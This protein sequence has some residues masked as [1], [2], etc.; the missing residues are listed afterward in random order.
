MNDKANRFLD[1]PVDPFGRTLAINKLK[2]HIPK[3]PIII[4]S[5]S[6]HHHIITKSYFVTA[7]ITHTRHSDRE[8]ERVGD[9]HTRIRLS[10]SPYLLYFARIVERDASKQSW[11]KPRHAKPSVK[12]GFDL[13]KFEMSR[14]SEG[15]SRYFET[16]LGLARCEF[17]LERLRARQR[18]HRRHVLVQHVSPVTPPEQHRNGR[19]CQEDRQREACRRWEARRQRE[20]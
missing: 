17:E 16:P 10:S 8:R 3:C 18:V 2:H 14:K 13:S 12:P 4:I 15:G 11:V 7:T 19:R 9:R 20:A 6:Y 5:S 1:L